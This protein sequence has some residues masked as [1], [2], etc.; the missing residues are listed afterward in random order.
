MRCPE[1]DHRGTARRMG[2]IF[3]AWALALVSACTSV[4]SQLPGTAM[5]DVPAAWSAHADILAPGTA[6]LAQWWLRFDDPMLSRLIAQALL[7]N[8]SVVGAQ[9]ALRQAR[10]LRDV[11][12]AALRPAMLASASAQHGAGGGNDSG[13]RFAARLDA[14]WELDLFGAQR[15]ALAASA[16]AA[17]ASAASLA[18]VQVSVCAEVAINYIAMRGAQ[19]RL[20]LA[21]ANLASQQTTFDITRWRL[22]AGLVSELEFEQARA[23]VAQTRAQLPAFQSSIEQLGH[24]LAGLAGRPPAALASA[25]A[26]AGPVPQAGESLALRIP[27]DTLRQRPDVRAA[28]HL[29]AL[30]MA[31]VAQANA[32]RLPDFRLAGSL[33]LSGRT[34]GAL[35]GGAALAGTVLAGMAAPWFDGGALRAQV[36]MQQGARDMALAAY[37]ASVLNALTEVEDALVALRSDRERQARLRLAAAAAAN[38][39]RLARQWFSSGIVD[40]QVVLD[41]QRTQ[42]STQ[43]GV[44]SAG[45]D[46]STDHVRLYKALGGGWNPQAQDATTTPAAAPTSADRQ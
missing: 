39:A 37:R 43:D 12:A 3:A 46:V 14:S 25:L 15:S 4:A 18:D 13:K 34:L 22:Q 7:T 41:T 9:A 30:A 27:A 45:I 24:A 10:A 17:A 40:F 19:A 23:A 1:R 6:E 8:T 21:R 42:L 33:G 26:E 35:S 29:V 28:E 5:N 32:A 31:R 16:A 2:V 44:V 11:S 38:A 36:R 20:A